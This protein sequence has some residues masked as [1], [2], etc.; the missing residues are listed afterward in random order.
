MKRGWQLVILFIWMFTSC[1]TPYDPEIPSGEVRVL[2]VEGYLDTEGMKSELKLSRAVPLS[3]TK[4]SSPETGAKISLKNKAGGEFPLVEKGSGTYIFQRDIDE[5]QTY[6]LEIILK[7][8]ERYLSEDLNPVL[9]PEI[10]DGGFKRD[11]DGVEVF[12]STKGNS[13]AD[14]FLWTFEETWI[15][16]PRI[17][18]SYI[19]VA[20]LKDVTTRKESEQNSLCF[21]T[22]LSPNIV[23]ETSSRFQDQV[24]FQKTVTEIPK[25]NERIMERYS[26]LISQKGIASKDVPFW[27][28]LKKNTE[29]IGSIFSPLPSLIGGNIKSQDSSNQPVI[30]QVSL[31]V[32]R[33][34]RIFI[35]LS[36][37]S[38]WNYID[39]KF[40]DCVIG[41]EAVLRANYQAAFGNGS[42]VPVRELMQG[43]TIIGYFPSS[44]RCTDC[45]LYASPVKPEFWED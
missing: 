40:N 14:D 29:D 11:E 33:Q 1:R 27:E 2:V 7:N 43:T 17:R 25:G 31:G 10:L 3:S 34:K 28:T 32:I 39:P 30:G 35:N 4:S 26:I 12:V 44:R 8:G 23:L 5:K 36:D 13:E 9:T 6:V 42:V 22:E 16:R 45:T 18:T 41:E 20:D 19:Y 15:Y 37:V 24:V 38:P 21:K